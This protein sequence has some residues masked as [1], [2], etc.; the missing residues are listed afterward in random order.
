MLICW[1]KTNTMKKNTEILLDANVEVGLEISAEKTKRM[2]K[3]SPQHPGLNLYSSFGVRDHVS[4]SCR[5]A[6]F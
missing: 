6:F 5:T 4:H 3:C 2:N 1:L